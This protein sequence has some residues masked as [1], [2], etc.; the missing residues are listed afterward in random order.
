MSTEGWASPA[1][2]KGHLELSALQ[3]N[4]VAGVFVQKVR[5]I[6]HASSQFRVLADSDIS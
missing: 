4:L 5:K 1:D 3:T 6:L 2:L